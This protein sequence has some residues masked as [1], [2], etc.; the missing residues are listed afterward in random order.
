MDD[1]YLVQGND[2]WLYLVCRRSGQSL[3]WGN[4]HAFCSACGC[5][6]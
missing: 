2:G 5:K 1:H 6:L 3:S 4:G